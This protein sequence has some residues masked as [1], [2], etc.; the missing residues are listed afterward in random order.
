[1]MQPKL[2]PIDKKFEDYRSK[3]K[4]E[5]SEAVS[6][7]LNQSYTYEEAVKNLQKLKAERLRSKQE[8]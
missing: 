2:L 3:R 4:Q 1:M 8:L 5:A 7:M 6:T